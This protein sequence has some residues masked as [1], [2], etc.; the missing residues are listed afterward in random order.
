MNVADGAVYLCVRNLIMM[1]EATLARKHPYWIGS[2]MSIEFVAMRIRIRPQGGFTDA[3]YLFH[4]SDSLFGIVSCNRNR[5]G[6]K[7]TMCRQFLKAWRRRW[8]GSFL[9]IRSLACSSVLPFFHKLRFS[10][11]IVAFKVLKIYISLCFLGSELARTVSTATFYE[12][13]ESS[14]GSTPLLKWSSFIIEARDVFND[15][16]VD[17][18]S[19]S[20]E[21]LS[22]PSLP[23]I[24]NNTSVYSL[25]AFSLEAWST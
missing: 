15:E 3:N 12:F 10:L 13:A 1:P 16:V 2:K 24:P 18:S 6:F 23:P 5:I 19:E 9:S 25:A 8:P 17:W 14:V 4:L 7:M 20:S 22:V 21:S 11:F